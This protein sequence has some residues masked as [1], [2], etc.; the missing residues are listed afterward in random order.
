MMAKQMSHNTALSRVTAQITA[1]V[2]SK[3]E[4]AVAAM[5]MLLT[6]VTEAAGY[7][8]SRIQAV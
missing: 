8:K 7:S 1:V 5:Y 4:L 3:V 2:L 6:A